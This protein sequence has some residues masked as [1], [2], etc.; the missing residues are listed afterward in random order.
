MTFEEQLDQYADVV[1]GHGVN[2]QKGQVLHVTSEVVNRDFVMRVAKKAYQRSAKLVDVNLLDSRLGRLRVLH[3]SDEG[4]DFVPA[5]LKKKFDSIVDTDSATL[6]IDGAED[7]DVLAGLD[8]Q[9]LVRIR[10]AIQAARKRFNN[11][12]I[13]NSG[14]QWSVAAAA[15]PAWARKVFPGLNDEEATRRLWGAILSITR[16]D[17][18]DAL[19]KWKRHNQKL[20]DRADTLNASKIRTL[21]FV[22]PG[23]DLHVGLSR[24][25]RFLGGSSKTPRGVDFEPNIPTEEVFTTP[26]WRLTNGRVQTTRPFYIS[27]TLVS[28]LTLI[29]RNGEIVEF[30]ADTGKEVFAEHI[31]TDAGACRLGEVALVGTDSPVFQSGLVFQET[32]FDENA[33]CHIAIGDAYVF[34]LKNGKNLNKKE[35]KALGRNDSMVHDDMMISSPEVQVVAE[36]Y[37]GDRILLICRGKWM[38]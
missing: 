32:L 31:K 6:Y 17:Q 36:T 34:C 14:I 33:A 10:K 29:F 13:M 26:D 15:T 12:G 37:G 28:G 19:E 35:L 3:S 11:E 30:S 8:T 22:G 20:H 7:P 21:R 2:L 18:P 24:Q 38:F 23:T 16:S 9:R 4:L 27:G 5:Y 25:A 1:I